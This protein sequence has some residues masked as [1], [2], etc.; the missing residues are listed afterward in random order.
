MVRL[1]VAIDLPCDITERFRIPQ[2]ILKASRARLSLV[3]PA[4]VHLTL[5][6]IGEVPEDRVVPIQEALSGVAFPPFPIKV[7]CVSTDNPSRPRVVWC[8]I[9]DDGRTA[10][11]HDLVENALAPF[12]IPRDTRRFRAHATIAR[13]KSFDPSLIPALRQAGV[14]EFGSCTVTSWQLKKSTLTP[15]GPVYETLLE[16]P[17]R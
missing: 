11:L 17:C 9:S 15:Q 1:F 14:E 12:G 3:N 7:G 2:E 6:F 5:K 16:V 8:G 10:L 13:V 4:I